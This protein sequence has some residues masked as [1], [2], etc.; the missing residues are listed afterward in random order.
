MV[1]EFRFPMNVMNVIPLDLL[2]SG[3]SAEIQQ[4]EGAHDDIH[5]LAELGIR[6][7]AKVHMVQPGFPCI[8]KIDD[9]RFTLRLAPD[10]MVMVAVGEAS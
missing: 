5:R 8:L 6:Q 7:G 9:Q 1:R 2:Q 4:V 10:V 3:E